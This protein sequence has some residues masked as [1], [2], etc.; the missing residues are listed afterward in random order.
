MK[1]WQLIYHFIIYHLLFNSIGYE[2]HLSDQPINQ[3][4]DK[5]ISPKL[6]NIQTLKPNTRTNGHRPK[7]DKHETQNK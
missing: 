4:T 5:R 6:W 3:S 7:G 2:N 1:N